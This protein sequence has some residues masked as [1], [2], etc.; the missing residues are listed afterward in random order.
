MP[1]FIDR[2]TMAELGDGAQHVEVLGH[3]TFREFHLPRAVNIPLPELD[4]RA[5][6]ELDPGR[7]VIV[8]CHDFA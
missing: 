2:N 1:A 7:P 6:Q 3:E 5:V 4:Q 8:Y